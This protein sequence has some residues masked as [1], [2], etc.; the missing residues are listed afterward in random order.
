MIVLDDSPGVN[1]LLEKRILMLMEVEESFVFLTFCH[2]LAL[3]LLF[4][5]TFLH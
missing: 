2:G 1:L 5:S 3:K 4:P